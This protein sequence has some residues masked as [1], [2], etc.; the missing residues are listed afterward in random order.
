MYNIDIG[1]TQS[2]GATDACY[3]STIKLPVIIISPQGGDIHSPAEW[4]SRDDF[5]RFYNVF[6]AWA[7]EEGKMN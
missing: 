4:M 3:F 5:H 2:H 7:I 6:K 1:E